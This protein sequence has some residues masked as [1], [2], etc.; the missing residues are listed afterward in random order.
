MQASSSIFMENKHKAIFIADH[1]GQFC[2]L[3]VN[4]L[5]TCGFNVIT[6]NNKASAFRK[7]R[8]AQPNI[9]LIHEEFP[10]IDL[11]RITQLI[12][13]CSRSISIIL[14][15][16]NP[17]VANVVA[18]FHRNVSDCIANDIKSDIF[19]QR[20][21]RCLTDLAP[22]KIK[23]PLGSQLLF[24]PEEFQILFLNEERIILKPME[25]ELLLLLCTKHG[26]ICTKEEIVQTLWGNKKIM[27][28]FSKEHWF[29]NINVFVSHLRMKLKNID[30]VHIENVKAVG[31]RLRVIEL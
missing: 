10:E 11:R 7:F 27:R 4:Y 30:Y 26:E 24:L 1:T 18:A 2:S 9:V 22:G 21:W 16:S 17:E 25:N 14:I 28:Q 3:H 13:I 31:Y 5:N 19:V 12:H 23:I 6:A 29:A 15:V 8:K 20:I